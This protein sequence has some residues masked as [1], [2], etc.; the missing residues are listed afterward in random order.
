MA[1]RK[2][3]KEVAETKS[4]GLPPGLMDDSHVPDHA[5]KDTGRGSEN[6]THEDIVIP[7]LEIVQSLSP[8]RDKNDDG[9]IEGAEE[10]HLFNTLTRNLYGESVIVV[11]VDFF[12]QYLV[13]KDRK[14][15]GGFRGAFNTRAEA[16]AR[17]EEAV[18]AGDDRRDDLDIIDTDQHI[19]MVV[20]SDGS[21]EEVAMSMARS[22]KKISRQLNSMVR[23]RGGDRFSSAY[24][25]ETYQD[26]NDNG[27]KYQNY[28][29]KPAGYV[30]DELHEKALALYKAMKADPNRY[31]VDDSQEGA[32]GTAPE[33]GATEY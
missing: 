21:T 5:T 28:R 17:V 22:K 9:Y 23:M 33:E 18:E 30:S 15:G 6:V 11:P 31:T 8:A 20:H 4:A 24:Y 25:L 19:A 29:F 27:D 1:T 2:S 7:R 26:E 32:T 13:W 3:N 16:E 10:G 14:A 12:K